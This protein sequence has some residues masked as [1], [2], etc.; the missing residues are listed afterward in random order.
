LKEDDDGSIWIGTMA[1]V[2]KMNTSTGKCKSYSARYTTT[3]K[4]SS[5]GTIWI[6]T[7]AGVFKIAKGSNNL[8]PVVDFV[9]NQDISNV[10]A[11]AEDL[12]KN[13][14]ISA[15]SI[16][17]VKYDSQDQQITIFNKN[18]GVNKDS[19]NYFAAY[20]DEYGSVY[21]GDATG[22]FMFKPADLQ[23]KGKAPEIVITNFQI[24]NQ[25]INSSDNSVLKQDILHTNSIHLKYDQN[26]FSFEF[27]P[28][29][30]NNPSDNRCFYKLQNYDNEWRPATIPA[31]AYYFNVP[32]GNYV[33][34]VKAVN[35]LGIWAAKT[36]NVTV[37]S[38]WWETWWFRVLSVIAL[39]I[40]VYAIIKERS[41]KL[42]AENLRLEQKVTERTAELK[43]SLEDLKATQQQLIHAEKMASLGEL[44]AGI[45]HEIQN[46]LNFVNNF[47][48]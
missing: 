30:Y 41:R 16:G 39:V 12:Q 21:I 5:D 6:G 15:R 18:A 7:Y 11:I 35:S 43:Q 29:D 40:V 31:K 14:W 1:G 13:I 24:G 48:K 46:P 45:A 42:K 37:A 36:I 4:K 23:S 32:P 8:V 27:H 22:Y 47:S 19:L 26:I 9:Y 20:A 2:C 17:L 25:Q 44:T 3:V 33:F 28:V 10:V 34:H 38:P